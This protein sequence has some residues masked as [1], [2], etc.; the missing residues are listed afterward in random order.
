MIHPLR[1][2]MHPC[3]LYRWQCLVSSNSGHYD[4]LSLGMIGH[5]LLSEMFEIAWQFVHQ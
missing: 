1:V 2:G 3:S 4:A 5:P